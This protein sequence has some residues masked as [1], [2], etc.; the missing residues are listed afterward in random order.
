MTCYLSLLLFYNSLVNSYTLTLYDYTYAL[1]LLFGSEFVYYSD[2]ITPSEG[3]NN[4]YFWY[5]LMDLLVDTL[6][7]SKLEVFLD[8]NIYAYLGGCRR[9]SYC[10][11][12][13]LY[14]LFLLCLS[15]GNAKFMGVD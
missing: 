10:S 7:R 4:D 8:E 14:A 3:G 15:L 11:W 9:D 13:K 1:F 6:L 5:D 12:L 2:T